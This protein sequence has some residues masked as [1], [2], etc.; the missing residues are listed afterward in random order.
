MMEFL[1]SGGIPEL[2][3]EIQN[4]RQAA[5]KD[6]VELENLEL[7]PEEHESY[8]GDDDNQDVEV[9]LIYAS[10]K[11]RLETNMLIFS[12]KTTMTITLMTSGIQKVTNQTL[13]SKTTRSEGQEDSAGLTTSAPKTHS[14]TIWAVP[15]STRTLVVRLPGFHPEWTSR[16]EAVEVSDRTS[17]SRV[18]SLQGLALALATKDSSREATSKVVVHPVASITRATS[19]AEEALAIEEEEA[20]S[21]VASTATKEAI[22]M[23]T[24][25]AISTVTSVVIST[26]TKEAISTETN[27]AILAVTTKEAILVGITKQITLGGITK[28]EI[29]GET[30]REATLVETTRVETLEEISQETLD[31]TKAEETR[32]ETLAEVDLEETS[33]EAFRETTLEATTRAAILAVLNRTL[34]QTRET[35]SV[36][37]TKEVLRS[38]ENQATLTDPQ[39]TLEATEATKAILEEISST[40]QDPVLEINSQTKVT[41]PM[42]GAEATVLGV[43]GEVVPGVAGELST[44]EAAHPGSELLFMSEVKVTLLASSVSKIGLYVQM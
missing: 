6:D 4:Y 7:R 13:T 43:D 42:N 12:L 31:P 3:E 30:T 26:V 5:E 9:S 35:T 8:Q 40:T 36:E 34:A 15:T 29:S 1:E 25:E 23:A 32:A 20:T 22:L 18:I 24:S 38:E 28:G 11:C 14:T 17:S 37:E 16:V 41:D 27:E 2:A 10:L 33:K 19:V 44:E 39:E 21:A